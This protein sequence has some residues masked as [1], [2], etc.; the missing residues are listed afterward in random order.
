VLLT[1][2][3]DAA[4]LADAPWLVRKFTLAHVP[5]PSNF[6]SLRKIA[7]GSRASHPWFGFGDFRPVTLAQA[8]KSFSGP[9][10]GESAKLLAGLPPLPYARKELEAA[11]ALLGADASDELVGPAFTAQGVLKTRLKDYRILQFSTH[12]LLPAELRCQSEPAIVTSAPPNATDAS[13]ALLTASEVVGLD[14]DADL[15]ILSAC[16][17]GGPGGTT[18][19]ESLSGLAR[20]FFYAG[21]RSLAVTHWSVNDQV[22]AFLV[23]DTL[24]RMKENPNLGIAG[25]LRNAQLAMLADAGKGLPA[26]IAHPFFWAP[27]AVI[28][29]GGER[30]PATAERHVSPST[31]AG[32]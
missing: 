31:L 30:G 1:G 7:T 17:S 16:N 19:G 11:R 8:E 10:C 29:E 24:R 21:A 12:A 23:V 22:A 13:G 3:A 5:A 26:E 2:P 25:A 27:F 32:L 6:V 4:R 15:V 18:A 14:L 20:A 28:G 9:G